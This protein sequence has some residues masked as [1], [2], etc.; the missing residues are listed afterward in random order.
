MHA[1]E[2]RNEERYTAEERRGYHVGMK[3]EEEEE[4]EKER[5]D[6]GVNGVT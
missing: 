6:E 1:K 5:G 3:E 4:E 2:A